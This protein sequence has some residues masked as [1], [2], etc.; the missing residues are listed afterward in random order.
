M[1]DSDFQPGTSPTRDNDLWDAAMGHSA[2]Q[3]QEEQ[4]VGTDLAMPVVKPPVCRYT[5][6][7]GVPPRQGAQQCCMQSL[8]AFRTR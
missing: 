4:Q 5:L 1:A 7:T 3:F 2:Q 8:S 6:G